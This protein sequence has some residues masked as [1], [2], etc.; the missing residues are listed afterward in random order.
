MC[1]DFVEMAVRPA[2]GS[3]QH[4]VQTIQADRERYLDP[5]H[6]SR[7]NNIELDPEAGDAGGGH[8]ARLRAS[9]MGG[10]CH[11]SNSWRRDAG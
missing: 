10:Q 7:F 4:K 8:A 5:A 6:D 9:R 11:G 2:H 3:L 1:T